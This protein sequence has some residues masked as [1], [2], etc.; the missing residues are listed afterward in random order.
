MQRFLFFFLLAFSSITLSAADASSFQRTGFI[1]NAGQWPAQVKYR[2]GVPSGALFLRDGGLSYV[3]YDG[4][5]VKHSHD[6]SHAPEE[7]STPHMIRHHAVNMQLNG[8][9]TG[10]LPETENGS[11]TRYNYYHGNDRSKW[12]SGLQA[13]KQVKYPE[14]YPHTDWVIYTGD[15]GIKYDFHIQ[16]GGNTDVIRMNFEG[17]ENI[18]IR[19]NTL[20]IR[21]S[22][23]DIVEQAPVAWQEENGVRTFVSAA[24][25]QLEDG[26][27]GFTVGAYD[28]S[29]KLTL[30]P[31]LVF[32]TYSGSTDD[33]WGYTAT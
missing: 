13:W 5:A 23:G 11:V 20:Y 32:A 33:N 18:S 17:Q 19:N 6:H 24:F 27:I 2:I 10:I 31:Q 8:A 12:A 7:T 30:D 4:A 15:A 28:H 1:P 9:N 21:T 26:S 25:R 22:L 29:K 14:I 3:L 16:P